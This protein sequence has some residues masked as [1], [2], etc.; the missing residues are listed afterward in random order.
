[1]AISESIRFNLNEMLTFHFALQI[2]IQHSHQTFL[3]NLKQ[4]D[5]SGAKAARLRVTGSCCGPAACGSEP[6]AS[7]LSTLRPSTVT[8]T[9]AV[10]EQ[11]Q[12]SSSAAGPEQR[13]PPVTRLDNHRVR[14]SLSQGDSLAPDY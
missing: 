14:P 11:Q 13:R 8:V 4:V 10:A 1:M 12:L 2:V 9:A 5:A 7:S 3:L 6:Q